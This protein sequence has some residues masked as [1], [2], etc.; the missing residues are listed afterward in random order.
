MRAGLLLILTLGAVLCMTTQPGSARVFGRNH[1]AEVEQFGECIL[2]LL[3][4]PRK[5]VLDALTISFLFCWFFRVCPAWFELPGFHWLLRWHFVRVSRYR[6]WRMSLFSLKM[7]FINCSWNFRLP[8]Q[9]NYRVT[10]KLLLLY[11]RFSFV[12]RCVRNMMD[13]F[14]YVVAIGIA[15]Y[16]SAR[17]WK[18]RCPYLRDWYVKWHAFETFDSW[19]SSA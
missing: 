12:V 9:H 10:L 7:G 11:L 17:P 13:I 15:I 14:Q 16:G 6:V 2:S 5:L 19:Y 3:Y 4:T 1:I 18:S 8:T